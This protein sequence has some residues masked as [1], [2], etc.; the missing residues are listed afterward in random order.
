M[1]PILTTSLAF[2]RRNR[3]RILIGGA[4]V[5]PI[6]GIILFMRRPATPEYITAIAKHGDVR[7]TVEVVGT[8]A[9]ERD[10]ALQF[11]V[12][13]IVAQVLVREGDNVKAGQ[14]LANLR[15]GTLAASVSA[16]AAAVAAAEAQ[17]RALQEGTRPEDLAIARAEVESKRA[18]VTAAET[19]LEN[20]QEARTTAKAKLSALEAETGIN[21]EGHVATVGSTIS[22][23]MLAAEMGL[24]GILDVFSNNDLQDAITRDRPE[25][26]Q[27]LEPAIRKTLTD[28]E[29]TV[30]R[31]ILVLT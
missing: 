29:A 23:N 24:N 11:P 1:H 13:G 4:I 9:S 2:A 6:V 7:R 17:L 22:K 30:R 26:W 5:V 19:A 27:L 14:R 16:Q 10:L 28:L 25:M 3:K 8:V 31:W 18:S 21:M 15:S 20:A 12:N